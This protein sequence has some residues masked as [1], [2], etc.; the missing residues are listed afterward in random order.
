MIL[1][2]KLFNFSRE[3][4]CYFRPENALFLENVQHIKLKNAYKQRITMIVK[5]KHFIS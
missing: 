2:A 4:I 5:T 3:I 1:Q